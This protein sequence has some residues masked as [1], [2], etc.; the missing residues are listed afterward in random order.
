ME[1]SDEDRICRTRPFGNH[2]GDGDK[3]RG[4]IKQRSGSKSMDKKGRQGNV[5][6]I[7]LDL[8]HASE[9]FSDV[10]SFKGD[11]DEAVEHTRAKKCL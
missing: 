4:D 8:L 2:G 6:F 7:F 3:A 1:I 5:Y 9:L 10:Y 11:V